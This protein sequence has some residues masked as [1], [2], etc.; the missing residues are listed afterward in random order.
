MDGDRLRALSGFR[1]RSLQGVLA[2]LVLLASQSATRRLLGNPG[3][4]LA[5]HLAQLLPTRPARRAGRL[6]H[7]R[8][9]GVRNL[10]RSLTSA[11]ALTALLDRRRP[12]CAPPS[13]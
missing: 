11:P 4:A 8:K 1:G 3:A 13:R 5:Q 2:A 9:R 6:S 7:L 10:P 12:R